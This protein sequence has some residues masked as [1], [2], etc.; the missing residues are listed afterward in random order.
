MDAGT[1]G[2]GERNLHLM[3]REQ[4]KVY[5]T[6]AMVFTLA[7]GLIDLVRLVIECM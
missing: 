2:G 1:D 5:F 6:V 3:T 7:A 4:M